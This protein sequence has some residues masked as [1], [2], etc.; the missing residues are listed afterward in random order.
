M[1]GEVKTCIKHPNA[2]KLSC[3]TV[4]LGEHLG[5]QPI[6]CGA[7]NVAVG[8]KVIVAPVGSMVYPTSGEPFEI[9][10]AKIR[11]EERKGMICAEDEIGQSLNKKCPACKTADIVIKRTGT[12]R[13]GN[14]YKFF[15]CTNYL[16]G[17]DY[18]TTEWINN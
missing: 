16:Y 8:Q 3:T 11:G 6:V 10:A 18:T 1:I 12:A 17:C 13:N 5:V 9:K 7:P 4:D 15:G 2:D 14:T